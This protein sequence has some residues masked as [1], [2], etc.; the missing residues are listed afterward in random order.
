MYAKLR[1][2]VVVTPLLPRDGGTARPAIQVHAINLK[3][4][5]LGERWQPISNES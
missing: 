4:I 2:V 3:E 5:M 1:A